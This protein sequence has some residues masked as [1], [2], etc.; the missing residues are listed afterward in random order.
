MELKIRSPRRRHRL[1][2]DI[3]WLGRG[4]ESGLLVLENCKPVSAAATGKNCFCWGK[5]VLVG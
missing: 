3:V 2:G 5:K 4:S 1:T